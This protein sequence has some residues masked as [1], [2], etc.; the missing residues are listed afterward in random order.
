MK[1]TWSK[2]TKYLVAVGLVFLGIY[3]LHL[4][5]SV[6]P[7]LVVA[8]LNAV[9]V[10]PVIS[11]LH[12]RVHLSRGL[13]V[14][15]VYLCLAI[16][17]PLV[18]IL[19]LPTIIDALV[20]VG[21]LD[22]RSIFENGAEWLRSTL[23]Q[24]K[25]AQLPVTGFDAYVDRA[26]D[27]VLEALQPI[28]PIPAVP[29][30]IDSVLQQLGSGLRA[31]VEAGA[32]LVG[33]VFSQVAT[34]LFIFLASIYISL[35]AHTYRGAFLQAL[36]AAYETEIST[37]LARIERTW[38][39]FFQGELTLMLVIGL[40]TTIGLTALGMPGALYLGIIAGLLELIPTIGPIIAAVPAAIVALVQGSTYLP[41]SNLAFAG[42]VILFYILVQQVENNL[43][44][45]RVLGAAVDLPPLVVITGA[46]VGASI[47]GILGVMLATPVIATGR[48]V[49]DY[50]YRKMM[51]REP[52]QIEDTAPESGMS[53]SANWLS[54]LLAAFR[55]R[56]RSLPPESRK[57]SDGASPP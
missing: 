47:G 33:A 36:P 51:D 14:G 21:S 35:D 25:A 4:S 40:I 37:L 30:P 55:K 27:M 53:R 22:Y 9:I 23:I 39:A 6:I 54:S 18:I 2:P 52:L 1:T 26:I 7:L 19:I 46:V 34:I 13:A 10:R 49:L 45:P 56:I 11:W 17:A 57:G 20:Y 5:R 32:N 43:I 42:L 12:L 44:V 16:L 8:A 50:L 38:N 31:A 28:S 3:I 15:L 48:E 29:P 41:I 24:F